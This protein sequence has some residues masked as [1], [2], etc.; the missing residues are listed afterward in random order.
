MDKVRDQI[1]N[2]V[3]PEFS[4]ASYKYKVGS[5][6]GLI[7]HLIFKKYKGFSI[8][9]FEYITWV[10]SWPEKCKISYHYLIRWKDQWAFR[11]DVEE[12]YE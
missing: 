7:L 6:F 8:G 1:L 3:N 2:S 9:K 10:C 4:R 12:Y 5:L 11:E